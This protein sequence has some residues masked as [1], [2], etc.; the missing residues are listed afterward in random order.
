[1]RAMR[2]SAVR[3]FVSAG[4]AGC[5]VTAPPAAIRIKPTIDLRIR[6][7]SLVRSER[8]EQRVERPRSLPD[9]L[10]PWVAQAAV[11]I[12]RHRLVDIPVVNQQL[13]RWSVA[14]SGLDRVLDRIAAEVASVYCNDLR[15]DS[16][17]R[18]ERRAVPQHAR[19]LAVV[20]DDETARVGQL[21]VLA[22]LLAALD[23]H[24]RLAR[25]DELV[26][27]LVDAIERSFGRDVVDLA[28]EIAAPI[29]RLHA[30]QRVDDIVE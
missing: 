30:V 9:L 12:E 15:S 1:M 21:V 22:V 11:P 3:V 26:S 7:P 13:R 10:Q 28:L 17:P 24:R 23:P 18:I 20:A 25:V 8:R 5:A 14:R 4:P 19:H 2:S 29:V 16:D 27:A 6:T